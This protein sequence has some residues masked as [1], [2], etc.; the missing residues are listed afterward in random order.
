MTPEPVSKPQRRATPFDGLVAFV[1]RNRH[2][3]VELTRRDIRDRYTGRVLGAAWS[4]L[5]PLG[6]MAVYVAVFTYLYSARLSDFGH[7]RGD[8]TAMLISGLIPWLVIQDVLARATTSVSSQPSLV[9]QI[10]FP[11]IVLPIK[12]VLSALPLAATTTAVLLIYQFAV[13]PWPPFTAILLLVYWPL[14][15]LYSIGLGLLLSAL[16]VFFRDIYD[17]LVL[18]FAGGLFLGPILFVPGLAPGW[19]ETAFWFNPF[20]YPIW[21]HRDLIFNGAITQPGAWIGFLALTGLFFLGGVKF[22]TG[23][24]DRFGDAL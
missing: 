9:R 4:I 6:L 10:A 5:S 7:F 24:E 14:F 15:A 11:T 20:S 18:I 16:A 19:L 21:V 13:G 3:I 12:T 23:V 22:F 1:R 8:Y 2:L 17:I